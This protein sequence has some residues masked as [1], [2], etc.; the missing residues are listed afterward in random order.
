VTISV[1]GVPQDNFIPSDGVRVL[2]S[3]RHVRWFR[4]GDDPLPMQPVRLEGTQGLRHL[5]ASGV[6]VDV[7]MDL[8]D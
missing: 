1:I 4:V 6:L 5:S 8:P 2:P 3:S 7:T